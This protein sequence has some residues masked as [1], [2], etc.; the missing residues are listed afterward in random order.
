[1]APDFVERRQDTNSQS[2]AILLKQ[3]TEQVSSLTKAVDELKKSDTHD[4]HEMEKVIE[5]AIEKAMNK[6]FP[7]GDAIGHRTAHEEWLEE[8]DER[9][10]MWAK[11]RSGLVEK[12]IWAAIIGVGIMASFYFSGAHPK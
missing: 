10:K 3:L 4:M 7:N 5:S 6:G 8:R 9:R 11:V 1:M 12:A 2:T